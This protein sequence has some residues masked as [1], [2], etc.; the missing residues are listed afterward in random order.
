[1]PKNIIVRSLVVVACLGILATAVPNLSSAG[2]AAVKANRV[3]FIT[4]PLPILSTLL[5]TLNPYYF[6]AG[7]KWV[8]NNSAGSQKSLVKTTGDMPVIR[9]STGD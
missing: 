8:S 6:E 5:P 4:Q 7:D 1:M 3:P 9:P 2:K